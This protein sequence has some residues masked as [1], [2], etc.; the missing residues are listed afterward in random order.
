MVWGIFGD[1]TIFV[2]EL[3]VFG[4]KVHSASVGC[5]LCVFT[6]V[7]AEE[8]CNLD[9]IVLVFFKGGGFCSC[10]S[11]DDKHKGS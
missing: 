8:E 3:E 7:Q 11:L 5:R 2:V 6:R 9:E 1:D 10:S 4:V